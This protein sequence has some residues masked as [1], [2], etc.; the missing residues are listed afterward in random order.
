MTQKPRT[1]RRGKN[2][3]KMGH[4]A[5]FTYVG[6]QTTFI[7]KLFKNTNLK[8]TFKTENTL[9]KLLILNEN[10]NCNKF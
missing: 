2:K 1:E 4:I 5:T 10:T 8:I 3:N 7:T 6:R 9:A